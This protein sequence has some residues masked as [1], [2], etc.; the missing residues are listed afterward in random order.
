MATQQLAE[1]SFGG[2][3]II[4]VPGPNKIANNA[5]INGN[6]GNLS[7]AER[8]AVTKFFVSRMGYNS[9]RL[10]HYILDGAL[11]RPVFEKSL[12]AVGF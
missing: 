7:H 9:K 11:Q 5:L 4:A 10:C 1:S 12:N 3:H 2:C 6:I 8:H